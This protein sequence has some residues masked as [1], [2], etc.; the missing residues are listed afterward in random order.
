MD[1]TAGHCFT[2]C[3]GIIIVNVVNT[4]APPM[5]LAREDVDAFACKKKKSKEGDHMQ[6]QEHLNS[7]AANTVDFCSRLL[8]VHVSKCANNAPVQ[9]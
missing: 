9:S 7:T 2:S 8:A 5:L 4:E 6:L 1:W 3:V